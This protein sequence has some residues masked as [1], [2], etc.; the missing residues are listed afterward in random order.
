MKII[1]IKGDLANFNQVEAIGLPC[2]CVSSRPYG[3]QKKVFNKYSFANLYSYREDKVDCKNLPYEQQPGKILIF[4]H[5]NEKPIIINM[6]IQVFPGFS[7]YPTS[8]LDGLAAREGYFIRCLSQIRGLKIKS[9]AF[10]DRI[11]C[12]ADG[13]NWEYYKEHIEKFAEENNEIQVYLVAY[14]PEKSIRLAVIDCGKRVCECP[15]IHTTPE[16]TEEILSSENKVETFLRFMSL[17]LLKN[18][19]IEKK[20]K[21]KRDEILIY[22]KH[23]PTAEWT[24]GE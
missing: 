6:L 18:P 9:I 19:R 8:K 17:R 12:G 2:N 14:E 16:E 11:G 20:I 22:L 7:A 10:P 13:G 5:E 23:H 4:K 24:F 21:D 1:E 3:L 15:L